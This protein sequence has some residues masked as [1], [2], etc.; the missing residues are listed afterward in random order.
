MNYTQW[1][2]QWLNDFVRP[3]SKQKTYIT[4]LWAVKNH[5]V[6]RLGWYEVED[7]TPAILQSFVAGL[8]CGENE[9]SAGTIN[10]IITVCRVRSNAHILWERP[11]YIPQTTCAVCVF[12]RVI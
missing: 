3:V 7:I 11:R 8:A 6:P 5:I 9:L 1:L 10:L 12:R 2:N 4:Y